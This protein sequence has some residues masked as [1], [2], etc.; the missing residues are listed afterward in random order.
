[1]K[2]EVAKL[3]Y[4]SFKDYCQKKKRVPTKKKRSTNFDDVQVEKR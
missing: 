3:K 4:F 1:L 2:S